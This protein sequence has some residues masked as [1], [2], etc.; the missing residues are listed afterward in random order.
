M[1]YA[2]V[3]FVQRLLPCSKRVVR[4]AFNCQMEVGATVE[5]GAQF[6]RPRLAEYAVQEC[7]HRRGRLPRQVVREQREAVRAARIDRQPGLI[8]GRYP[9][10]M[11]EK[12][13]V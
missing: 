11:H 10:L 9:A 13:V 8:P 4:L 12:R 6:V 1:I 3:T 5:E 7:V 2:L